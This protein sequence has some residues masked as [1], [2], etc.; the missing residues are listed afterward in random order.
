MSTPKPA[1]PIRLGD[2]FCERVTSKAMPTFENGEWWLRGVR[3]AELCHPD[4]VPIAPPDA[5]APQRKVLWI[6]YLGDAH[7]SN[8]TYCSFWISKP[9]EE[10]S[11]A[12]SEAYPFKTEASALA[13]AVEW[14]PGWPGARAIKVHCRSRRG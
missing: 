11:N 7:C 9:L 10:L 4:G 8:G 13:E 12:R 14:R 5:V 1:R 3:L 6:V 2:P